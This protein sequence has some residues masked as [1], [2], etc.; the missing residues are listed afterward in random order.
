M[1]VAPLLRKL[2]LVVTT[3]G[4]DKQF[5]LVEPSAALIAERLRDADVAPLPANVPFVAADD[6]DDGRALLAVCAALG[7]FDLKLTQ[8]GSPHRAAIKRIAKVIG[9]DDELLERLVLL[10]LDLEIVTLTDEDVIRPAITR[11]RELACGRVSKRLPVLTAFVDRLRSGGAPVAMASVDRWVRAACRTENTAMMRAQLL[12]A[13]PGIRRGK[14]GEIDVL[15]PMTLEGAACAS[16]TPSFEVFVPPESRAEHLV[17]ILA[18]AELVRLDRV[19]VARI[20]KASIQRAVATGTPPAT[21]VANLAATSRTPL[22]QNVETAIGDWAGDALAVTAVGR[23]VVVP[24][25]QEARVLALLEPFAARALAP[26]VIVVRAA[27]SARA[28][29]G[30]FA[31]LGI[32]LRVSEAAE[33]DDGEHDHDRARST[34]IAILPPLSAGDPAILRRFVAYRAGDADELAKA[35]LAEQTLGRANSTEPQPAGLGVDALAGD[36]ADFFVSE[37]AI[38]L[39]ERWEQIH[40]CTLDDEVATTAAA[41]IDV[42]ASVDQRFLLGAKSPA[43]L[44]DRIRNVGINRSGFEAFVAKTFAGSGGVPNAEFFAD[45]LRETGTDLGR[46]RDRAPQSTASSLPARSRPE[47]H[48]WVTKDLYA[49]LAAAVR[50]QS[51]YTLDLGRGQVQTVR[52][53]KLIE[54]GTMTMVLGENVDDESAVAVPLDG[55]VGIAEP[56]TLRGAGNRSERAVET[57]SVSSAW[58]PL[59]GQSPPPGHVACPCGSGARYRSCCRPSS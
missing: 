26:G 10:G 2:L 49:R 43:Q 28:L 8:A 59:E 16:I 52:I 14:V 5:N 37:R 44:F 55:I 20:S 53:R 21:I 46:V 27:T 23:V 3:T 40:G 34:S 51:T 9:V 39:V 22:P 32:P 31:R 33:D 58:R 45:G 15:A 36:G 47:N 6:L 48:E 24:V 1:A 56:M 35:P 4:R 19:V 7:Q 30:A 42:V 57:R 25:A 41:L 50:T 12:G 38:G 17:D 11:L 18:C 13:V 54:R 29:T